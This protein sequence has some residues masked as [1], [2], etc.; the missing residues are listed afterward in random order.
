MGC[1]YYLC[2][3]F[4]V[5]I[6]EEEVYITIQRDGHYFH[7]PA[8]YNS[9]YDEDGRQI[10]KLLKESMDATEKRYSERNGTIFKDGVWLITNKSS[11]SEYEDKIASNRN[12]MQTYY[13]PKQ[14]LKYKPA[15]PFS[16]L[17]ITQIDEVW[18]TELR[19]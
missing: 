18:C 5:K 14:M 13:T 3:M 19:Y 9:D 2:R 12:I 15:K 1:D 4:K 16:E 6:G 7:P 17:N 11:I 8:S 10:K